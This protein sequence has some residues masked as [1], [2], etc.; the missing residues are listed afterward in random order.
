DSDVGKATPTTVSQSQ[1]SA[2]SML[3][4]WPLTCRAVYFKLDI[5]DAFGSVYTSEP[6]RRLFC[7][8][9]VGVDGRTRLWMATRIPQGWRYSPIY[10]HKVMTCF[11]EEVRAVL[12]ERGVVAYVVNYQDDLLGGSPTEKDAQ[13]AMKIIIDLAQSRGLEIRRDKC[14]Q[15]DSVNFCGL[16]VR[17]SCVVAAEKRSL[18]AA[19]VSEALSEFCKTKDIGKRRTMI[20]QWCGKFQWFRRWLPAT[21]QVSL[22]RLHKVDP[23]SDDAVELATEIATAYSSGLIALH[24]I[25]SDSAFRVVASL[26][27]TDCNGNSR[28]SMLLHVIEYP[29]SC[30]AS[31]SAVELNGWS[32]ASASISRSVVERLGLENAADRS[33]AVLPACLDG[34]LL[35][36]ADVKRSSTYKERKSQLLAAYRFLPMMYSPAFIVTD[37]R[38]STHWWHNYEEFIQTE[39][40][41]RMALSFER[42]VNNTI[43]WVPRE[44]LSIVDKLAR[45][46]MYPQSIVKLQVTKSQEDPLRRVIDVT[47]E[48]GEEEKADVVMQ[49][50][51]DDTPDEF[52][53]SDY[54]DLDVVKE[55]QRQCP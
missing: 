45:V 4:R 6:L 8:R 49:L 1:D 20:R 27:V 26:I 41:L 55:E 51:E 14:E 30:A 33:Y 9:T 21:L 18:S 48:E 22:H 19:V 47:L 29:V 54:L 12:S 44:E 25:G 50:S 15:G 43:I 31:V 3:M 53:Y 11:L 13:L 34:G 36:E 39:G 2:L 42:N 28:G 37:N 40:D 32:D 17:G 24:V 16:Q 23:L 38:N 5:S 7:T 52:L 35:T 46:D 10:F